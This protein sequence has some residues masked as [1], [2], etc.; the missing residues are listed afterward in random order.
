MADKLLI[1]SVDG[2]EVESFLGIYRD[3]AKLDAAI[4]EERD[5]GDFT[6]ENGY[7]TS[8]PF[9]GGDG[10][11]CIFVHA[12]ECDPYDYTLCFLIREA[13]VTE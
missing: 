8:E 9:I 10:R 12:E 5:G 2:G 7:V 3:R 6:V 11:E 4:A 13:E 1:L